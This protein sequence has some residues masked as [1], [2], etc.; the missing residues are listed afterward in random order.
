MSAQKSS[1]VYW[2]DTNS[3]TQKNY[4]KEFLNHAHKQAQIL[5]QVAISTSMYEKN[6]GMLQ[7]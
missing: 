3:K 2:F 5:F 1:V 6:N 7:N 4:K